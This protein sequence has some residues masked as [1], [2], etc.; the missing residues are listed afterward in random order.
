MAPGKESDRAVVP[1]VPGAQV[2]VLAPTEKHRS[3]IG[4]VPING[5]AVQVMR[6]AIHE[7]RVE[8]ARVIGRRAYVEAREKSEKDRR[9]LELGIVFR[10]SFQISRL[11]LAEICLI[12]NVEHAV[13]A[14]G[15]K[16]AKIRQ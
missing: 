11:G 14:S 12:E 15:G 13:L 9:F 8:F 1:D 6:P 7:V 16:Q 5:R 3:M 2:F 10:R 4:T